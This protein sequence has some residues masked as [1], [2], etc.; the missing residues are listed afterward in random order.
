[1]SANK[2]RERSACADRVSSNDRLQLSRPFWIGFLSSV[3]L[4]LCLVPLWWAQRSSGEIQ[5][6]PQVFVAEPEIPPAIPLHIN[7]Q[8]EYWLEEFRT[9]RNAELLDLLGRQGLFDS[10][11]RGKLQQRRMPE[12]LLYLAM[13]ESGF[14]P[15][16]VSQVSAVGLWQFMGPTALQFGLRVDNYVDERRDPVRATDAALDYIEYLHTRFDS[17][18][19][20]AAA[21]NAG[22]GRVERILNRYAEGRIGDEEIYWEVLRYLPRETRNYVPRFIAVSILAADARVGGVEILQE[23]PY[24]YDMVFV[25]GET[26]LSAVAESLGVRERVLRN[27]NPHLTRGVTPPNEIYEVRV[28]KGGT[29]AVVASLSSRRFVSTSD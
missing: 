8:V 7:A 29:S 12:D 20:A 11:I 16:A 2:V 28:P 14:S 23:A 13:I 4:S 6:S 15:W 9:T 3:L 24:E 22:P 25:P 27:L 17:W 19:L 21:Y 18:Y 10:L 5:I 26:Y 1:M